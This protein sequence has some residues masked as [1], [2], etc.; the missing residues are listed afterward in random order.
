MQ[1]VDRTLTRQ[2][3]RRFLELKVD[4]VS[5]VDLP[6]NE[7]DFVVV[8]SQQEEQTMSETT[9]TNNPKTERVAVE[10]PDSGDPAVAKA[11]E[12]VQNIVESITKS[13][14]PAAKPAETVETDAEKAAK[15]GKKKAGYSMNDMVKAILPKASDDEIAKHVDALK[16]AGF[17]FDAAA[18]GVAKSAEEPAAP[19]VPPVT[20]EGV[21]AAFFESVAKAKSFTPERVA[22]LKQMVELLQKMLAEVA[23]GASPATNTPGLKVAPDSGIQD[24]LGEKVTKALEKLGETLGERIGKIETE[25]SAIKN[26]TPAP[27][28]GEPPGNATESTK[29]SGNMWKGVL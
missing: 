9:E 19:A 23:P 26:A 12:H 10:V 21:L 18:A 2:P 3:K 11:L 8:K 5:L 22:A 4:E 6:A 25:V 7:K 14:A 13:L 27:A 16:K 20:Q 15:G 17:D 1:K 29:K 24:L 28:G